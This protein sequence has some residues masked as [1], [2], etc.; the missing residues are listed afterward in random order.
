M[1]RLLNVAEA[2][3]ERVAGDDAE[4][5][6]NR[7]R[8]YAPPTGKTRAAGGRAAVRPAPMTV[9]QARALAAQLAAEDA[10]HTVGQ[11]SAR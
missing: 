9:E 6:R 8:L 11:R 10:R 4:R 7:A 3:L 2:L 5:E 1:T